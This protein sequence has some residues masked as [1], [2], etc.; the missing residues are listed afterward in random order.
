[1]EKKANI[2]NVILKLLLGVAILCLLFLFIYLLLDHFGYAS[3]SKEQF[4]DLIEKTGV[5]GKIVFIFVTFLQVTFIP[6][7][8]A[9][10]ILAGSYL[11]GFWWSFFL[12]FIGSFLGSMFAFFLGRIIGRKFVDWATGSKEETDYYLSKLKGKETVL[13]FFMFILPTFP[14]DAL[15]S[16]AGITNMKTWIFTIMQIIT[17]PISILGTLLFMSGEIIPLKGWGIV[18]IIFIAIISLIAF[19]FAFKNSNKINESLNK[20]AINITNKFRKM[21]EK[22]NKKK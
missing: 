9:V 21:K 19:V 18:L 22:T 16:I 1:M 10:T 13:L 17:R 14:D 3:L 2:K 6:I 12:S 7:P 15:C 11:F 5:Y 4:Q 20:L 8:S